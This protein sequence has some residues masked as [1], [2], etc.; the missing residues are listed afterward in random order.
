MKPNQP[1][2]TAELHQLTDDQVRALESSSQKLANE[3][4]R[5]AACYQRMA[6]R[7]RK[8]IKRRKAA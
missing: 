7:A 5:Q 1:L 8:E 6:D 2:T 3:T 4:Q